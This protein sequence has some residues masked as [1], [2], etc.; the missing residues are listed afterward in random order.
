MQTAVNR[1]STGSAVLVQCV[2]HGEMPELGLPG[3]ITCFGT[4]TANAHEIDGR[5]A[6]N[7]NLRLRAT[8]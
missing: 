2:S 5:V 1:Y 6:D 7:D 8:N 3:V 4:I